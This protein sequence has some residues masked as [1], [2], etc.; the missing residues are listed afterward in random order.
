MWHTD[1]EFE[2]RSKEEW[3]MRAPTRTPLWVVM[4]LLGIAVSL[5][6]CGTSNPQVT[7]IPPTPAGP[8][9]AA[10]AARIARASAADDIRE[11]VFRYQFQH[12]AS[13]QQRRARVYGLALGVES[14]GSSPPTGAPADID[15]SDAFMQRFTGNQP[16]V[17]KRSQCI[18]THDTGVHDAAT[19]EPGLV[20]HVA[21][22]VWASDR[23]AVV[24]GGYY[25]G[26]LSASG[27]EYRVEYGSGSWVVTQN[28]MRWIA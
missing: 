20:F 7:A 13:G 8:V 6:A 28:T 27:N 12:N 2:M 24:A 17:A 9:L 23:E 22:I 16:P 19:G 14:P 4:S 3:P 21:G 15:P 25:E 11:A 10:P 18:V 1:D 5:T 26:N